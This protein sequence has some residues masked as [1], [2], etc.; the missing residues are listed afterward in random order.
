MTIALLDGDILVYECGFAS[1]AGAKANGMAHEPF[2]FARHGLEKK[3][4]AI[5][6]T[7]GADNY[8][9]CLTGRPKMGL[10]V[11]EQV[12]PEYKKNRDVTHRPHWYKQLQAELINSHPNMICFD[13]LEAD[14]YLAILSTKYADSIIC[15]KDKDLDQVPGLHYNWSKTKVDKGVYEVSEVEGHRTLFKQIITGDS[16]DNIPGIFRLFG[17]KATK[18][19]LDP[20]DEMDDVRDMRGYAYKQYGEDTTTFLRTAQLIYI[21]RDP[22]RCFIDD[23]WA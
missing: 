4:D 3:I 2:G 14:D 13:G 7:V 8:L 17:K 21:R 23:W 5:L 22:H 15:S 10:S 18:K 11:R 9:V 1:D 16:T 6:Q 20:I 12:F 19:I